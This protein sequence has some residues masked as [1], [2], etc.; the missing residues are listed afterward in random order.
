MQELESIYKDTRDKMD[1]AID[2]LRKEIMKIR[3]GKANISLLNDITVDY[4]GQPSPLNHIGTISVPEARLILINPWEK[5]MLQAIERAILASDLGIT[6]Q[7]DG[8]V[9]RLAFPP[10]TED[11]R[12]DLG[13]LV[14][15]HG[16]EAKI[17]VRNIRRIANDDIKKL[18]KDSVISEDNSKDGLDEIQEITDEFTKKIDETVEHKEKEIMEI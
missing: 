13:K 14:K 4:Y 2:A 8:N 3:T 16:E 6:P 9:I 10:L 17:E 18:E 1:K 7:S 15:K 5:T 11:R 12:K